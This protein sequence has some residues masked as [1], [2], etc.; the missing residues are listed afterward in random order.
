MHAV[1]HSCMQMLQDKPNALNDKQTKSDLAKKTK[2]V[3]AF[4]KKYGDFEGADIMFM[5]PD[6]LGNKGVVSAPLGNFWLYSPSEDGTIKAAAPPPL[7]PA[8]SE[9]ELL[10][11]EAP[12]KGKQKLSQTQQPKEDKSKGKDTM[13]GTSTSQIPQQH[14]QTPKRSLKP[15]SPIAHKAPQQQNRLAPDTPSPDTPS[16]T[17][18]F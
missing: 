5:G 10:Q 8:P 13:E 2:Y 4:V 9:A 11:M 12:A 16:S 14:A 17:K 15:A 7:A 18:P 1:S 6:C 3:K